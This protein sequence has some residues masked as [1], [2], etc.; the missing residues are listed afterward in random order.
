MFLWL[1][2]DE[3]EENGFYSFF[4]LCVCP[5][6]NDVSQKSKGKTIEKEL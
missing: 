5:F 3:R 2:V 4:F 6:P 1:G